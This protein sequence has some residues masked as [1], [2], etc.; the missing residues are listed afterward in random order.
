MTNGWTDDD[1]PAL[2]G[3]RFLITGANTGLGLETARVLLRRSAEVVLLCRDRVRG[4][5]ALAELRSNAPNGKV[6]LELL[7]LGSLASVRA[8]AERELAAAAPISSLVCNAGIMAIPERK[9]L[10]GFEMQ[11]GVNHL[12]HFALVGL[13]MKKLG[14][15]RLVLVSSAY[16]KKGK[17]ELLDDLF[18]EKRPYHRWTAYYQSK[19]A[20]LLFMFELARRC[21]RHGLATV[22]VGAH[23]GYSATELQSRGAQLGSPKWEGWG[24][25]IGNALIAQSVRAGAWPQLRAATDPTARSGDYFGP[26][27]FM[28]VRGKAVRVEAIRAARDEAA[29]RALWTKSEELTNVRFFD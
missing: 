11:L 7:D 9:T 10:D 17:L 4:E 23:P 15:S 21:E 5:S 8:F 28:E 24:M 16:H 27:G 25:A 2:S 13:L 18:F 26:R 1:I 14:S 3:M 6:S 22:A 19:L 29:A 20:N 12:G